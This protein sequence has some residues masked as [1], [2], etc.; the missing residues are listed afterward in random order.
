MIDIAIEFL[1]AA[2]FQQAWLKVKENNGCAGI[3]GETIEDFG[4]DNQRNLDRLREIIS[5]S[6]YQ[7]HP[8]K[9]VLIPKDNGKTREL[10]I[11][12]VRDRIIQQA[13][14]NVLVPQVEPTFSPCSFAYRPNLS[15]VKAVEKIADWRDLGYHWILDADIVKYF[16]SIDHQIL[17]RELRQHIDHP[18]ILCLIKAWI[19]AGIQVNEEIILQV[20]GIPQGAVISPLLANIYLDKFDRAISNTDLKLVRYADDFLI[21]AR[22][23]DRIIQTYSEVVRLLHSLN[24]A[25]HPDKTQ[26]TN[27]ERGFT[28]LGHGFLGEAI[29]PVDKPKKR[30][31][32]E[33]T[34]RL[35]DKEISKK[36]VQNR[37]R[38][39]Q[40]RK[41]RYRN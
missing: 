1:A 19:S 27:F 21:L 11:P 5:K 32:D 16:D 39:S 38:Y 36:K 40:R 30:L 24:L 4:R 18:G 28:F 31:G 13:L 9:Q 6:N 15:I 20:K 10:R 37:K 3:D 26:I 34:E 22:S 12:T 25:I 2:N 7:P 33:E 8:L 14:L 35:R 23:R 29:F 17:L 41:N